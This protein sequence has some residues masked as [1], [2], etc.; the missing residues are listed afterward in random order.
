MALPLS[1]NVRVASADDEPLSVT[2]A[3]VARTLKAVSTSRAGGPDNLPNWLLKECA[4]ILTP[5]IADI[6]NISFLECRVPR[7]WKL[8]DV[9]PL[10]KLFTICDFFK[11]LWPISLAST[12]SKVAEDIVVEKD[13]KTTI[14][15]SIDPGQFGVIGWIFNYLCSYIDAPPSRNEKKIVS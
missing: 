15:S 5:P 1:E 12:L 6:L 14:L 2:E 8:A 11:D 3:T 10:P 13:L 9:P 4:D 7:V